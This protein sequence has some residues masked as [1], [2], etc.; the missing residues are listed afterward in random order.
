M[1]YWSIGII[2]IVGVNIGL[3][4]YTYGKLN[5]KVS[6]LCRRVTRLEEVINGGKK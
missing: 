4:A 6:D 3:V 2:G 1:E 5:Q